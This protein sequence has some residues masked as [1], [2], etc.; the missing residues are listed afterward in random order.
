MKI[1]V[2]TCGSMGDVQPMIATS[3]T[4]KAAGSRI[5][6]T[7]SIKLIVKAVEQSCL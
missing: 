3:L 7:I 2:A 6:K 1:V 4:L 5:D